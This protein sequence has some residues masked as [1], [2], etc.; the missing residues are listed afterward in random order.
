MVIWLE[1]RMGQ[2]TDDDHGEDAPH[3]TFYFKTLRKKTDLGLSL[4][5]HDF[6]FDFI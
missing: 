2:H 5:A 3:F 4:Y 1:F 6:F